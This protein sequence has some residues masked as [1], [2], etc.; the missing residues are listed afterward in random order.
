MAQ[1]AILGAKDPSDIF[2]PTLIATYAG[3][4]VAFIAVALSSAS[5]SL[6]PVILAWLGGLTAFV[7]RDRLV[8]QHA[9]HARADPAGLE[10]GGQPASCFS[11]IV[12]FIAGALWKKV[13]VYDVFIEG[14]KGGIQ[15]SIMIIP[16]LVGHAGGDRRAAQFRRARPHRRRLSRG[17]SR[18]WASTPTSC[19]RCPRR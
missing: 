17:P 6:D 18:R 19:P 3:T 13:N 5:A 7:V 4:L 8:L 2:I 14:A 9:A 11:V 1:R 16:F 10:G 12:G 15:T